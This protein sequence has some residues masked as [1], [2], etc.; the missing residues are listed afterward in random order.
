MLANCESY[1]RLLYITLWL[2]WS[3]V[4]EVSLINRR[5][6]ERLANIWI[7]SLTPFLERMLL[8]S[9]VYVT[10]DSVLKTDADFIAN[11]SFSWISVS[12]TLLVEHPYTSTLALP[13]RRCQSTCRT[14]SSDPGNQRPERH[15][16]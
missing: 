12:S 9:S 3:G 2:T 10:H 16:I 14:L 7:V 13:R 11:L 5:L 15:L 4:E 8:F 6:L 1:G